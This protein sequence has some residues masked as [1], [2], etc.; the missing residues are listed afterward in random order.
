[1]PSE[2]FLY[3]KCL[4]GSAVKALNFVT[5]ALTRWLIPRLHDQAIIKQ[6]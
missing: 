4:W 1:M 6:T 3:P 5:H 2:R